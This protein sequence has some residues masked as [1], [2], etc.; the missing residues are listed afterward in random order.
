MQTVI[1]R[2]E[3]EEYKR[4]TSTLR[5]YIEQASVYLSS[6][7]NISIEEAQQFVRKNMG[8]GGLFEFK[9]PEVKFLHRPNF[10]DRHLETTTMSRF[11]SDVTKNEECLMPTFTAYC[12]PD[13]KK[14]LFSLKTADNIAARDRS[15]AE[16]FV[17]KNEGN[18]VLEMFK[19][20]EQNNKKLGNNALSGLSLTPSTAGFN[21]T[22]HSTL[23]TNC[24]NTTAYGNT[25]N[26]KFIEGNR[27]YMDVN[28][29]L[30]NLV[31]ITT[32]TDMQLVEIA[33]RQF[34][35]AIPTVTDVIECINRSKD[36]YFKSNANM[37]RVY[38]FIESM[39]PMARCAFVYVGDLYHLHKH[40]PDF[41]MQL[42]D[43]MIKTDLP[44]LSNEETAVI[45]KA[46]SGD[47]INLARQ[48]CSEFTKGRDLKDLKN[49]PENYNRLSAV[50]KNI[51]TTLVNI[52][53]LIDAFWLT[54]NMPASSGY[55]PYSLRR[56][57][58]G[59]D[60]DSTLFTVQQWII[61]KY[62]KIGF[63]NPMKATSDSVIYLASQTVSHLHAKMSANYGMHPS[64]IFDTVMKN[65]YRFEWFIPTMMAK[66]YWAAKSAQEGNV[67]KDIELELKGANMISSATPGD[68]VKNVKTFLTDQMRDLISGKDVYLNDLLDIISEKENQIYNNIKTGQTDYFKQAQIKPAKAYKA[69]D[70]NR[71]PYWNHLFWNRT[72]GKY[73]G[74]VEEPPY[75]MLKVSLE[76]NNVSEFNAWLESIPNPNLV[77][78]IQEELALVNRKFI[79]TAYIPF[80][81]VQTSGIPDE[82]LAASNAR[83]MV[84]ESCGAYYNIL[85]TMGVSMTNKKNTR[86]VFD[87][88]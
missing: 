30:H 17:A 31:S 84:R 39:K 78:D 22:S 83:K 68:I 20:L 79:T 29:I 74:K 36:L 73:Y 33:V 61:R 58:L 42:L 65:E 19:N 44:P 34:G 59:G 14:S 46:V 40:N 47:M 3:R 55:F 13:V 9:D 56:S 37:G 57:V 21:P 87:T 72:F 4:E 53:P 63:T 16:M 7:K 64:M 24:R 67:F 27:H 32:I 82:I 10:A 88:Y 25:N 12:S 69:E 60:T 5:D 70:E 1:F 50:V 43:D 8:P 45:M 77:K 28:T 23:T 11:L 52:Q 75:G 76:I 62:G 81:I 41:V 66:H 86:M 49:E 2:K 48:H 26:E 38:E 54:P 15:K 18:K 80:T 85:E 6:V 51:N 71:T 35:L